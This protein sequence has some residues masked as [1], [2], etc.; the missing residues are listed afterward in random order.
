MKQIKKS[1]LLIFSLYFCIIIFYGCDTNPPHVEIVH[2]NESDVMEGLDVIIAEAHD[3]GEVVQVEFLIDGVSIGTDYKK[4]WE[5]V[6]NVSYW[7]DDEPHIISA[8][9]VDYSDNIGQSGLVTVFVPATAQV[10]PYLSYPGLTDIIQ[11]TNTINDLSR[12]QA[13]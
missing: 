4:P 2:P 11:D 1:R 3:E 9:A 12:S 7:A 5:Y 8:K 13:R 6:W 10:V